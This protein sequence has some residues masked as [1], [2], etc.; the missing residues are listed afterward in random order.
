MKRAF[1]KNTSFTNVLH[2]LI[3][4]RKHDKKKKWKQE[5]DMYT[6]FLICVTLY[7]IKGGF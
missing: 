7:S 2:L 1:K 6:M 4:K 5:E 3:L